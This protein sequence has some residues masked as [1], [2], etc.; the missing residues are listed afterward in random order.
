MV[1]SNTRRDIIDA[2][3]SWDRAIAAT[4]LTKSEQLQTQFVERFPAEQ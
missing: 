3:K 1:D 4:R 2:L